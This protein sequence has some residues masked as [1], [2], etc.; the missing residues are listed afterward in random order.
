MTLHLFGQAKQ[1]QTWR[2]ELGPGAVVLRGFAVPDATAIFAALHGITIQA[3]FRYAVSGRLGCHQ[4]E[5]GKP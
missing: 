1:G 3:P 5:V 4:L 2:E